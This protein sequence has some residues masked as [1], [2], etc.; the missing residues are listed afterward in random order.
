MPQD[1][2]VVCFDD[3]PQLTAAAPF[4]T[5][6]VQPASEMGRVAIQ[7]LLE[8]LADPD[9]PNQDIVLPTT[10][11]VRGS[12]GCNFSEGPRIGTAA[13]SKEQ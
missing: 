1:V 7:L 4:L 12:C 11:V 5:T 6:Q 13:I 2:A 3:T 10:L 9:R 8:R